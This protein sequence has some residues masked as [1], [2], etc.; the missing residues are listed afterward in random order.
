MQF[1]GGAW[2]V[3]AEVRTNEKDVSRVM[4][5]LWAW[6]RRGLRYLDEEVL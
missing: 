4:Y 1:C 5:L 2:E 3:G 6:V